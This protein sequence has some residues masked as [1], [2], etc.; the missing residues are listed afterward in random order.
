MSSS[1]NSQPPP[2]SPFQGVDDMPSGRSHTSGT[3]YSNKNEYLNNMSGGVAP[4][5]TA[6][7][8]AMMGMP[9]HVAG[10]VSHLTNSNVMSSPQI[11]NSMFHTNDAL[12]ME[13]RVGAGVAGFGVSNL[14]EQPFGL[15]GY[16][17]VSTQELFGRQPVAGTASARG[18]IHSVGQ[19]VQQAALY[20]NP[21]FVGGLR[22]DIVEGFNYDLLTQRG[23]SPNNPAAVASSYNNTITQGQQYQQ[24]GMRNM[25]AAKLTDARQGSE[26]YLQTAVRM[27]SGDVYTGVGNLANSIANQYGSLDEAVQTEGARGIGRVHQAEI[28][29]GVLQQAAVRELEFEG[30]SAAAAQVGYNAGVDNIL[31]DG[32]FTG[33][34]PSGRETFVT[35]AGLRDQPIPLTSSE[36]ENI[37]DVAGSYKARSKADAEDRAVNSFLNPDG[38]ASPF[39]I[40]GDGFDSDM[41]PQ[42]GGD[43]KAFTQAVRE[44]TQALKGLS[45]GGGGMGMG[46][47]GGGGGAGGGGGRIT[48]EDAL[49][50]LEGAGST[51]IGSRQGRLYQGA[52]LGSATGFVSGLLGGQGT[53]DDSNRRRAMKGMGRAAASVV[54][55]AAGS[56]GGKIGAS[57]EAQLASQPGFDR[58]F[59]GLGAFR[60]M[61]NM[62][63][64]GELPAL[65]ASMLMGGSGTYA[66]MRSAFGGMG[67]GEG[68]GISKEQM[69]GLIMPLA[70]SAGGGTLDVTKTVGAFAAGEDV[71]GY[72]GLMGQQRQAGITSGHAMEFNAAKARGLK[73]SAATGFASS[74]Y[75]A[76][77]GM[78]A[79][80]NM[81]QDRARTEGRILS[82]GQGNIQRGAGVFGRGAGV[83][84]GAKDLLLSPFQ[85]VSDIILANEALSSTGSYTGAVDRLEQG[86]A[87]GGVGA[88][89]R[90]NAVLG[91]EMG[92]LAMRQKG[93]SGRD[94]RD[95]ARG[96]AS[97]GDGATPNFDI[98]TSGKATQ[99]SGALAGR[100]N[101]QLDSLY[102]RMDTFT[103]MLEADK[104]VETFLLKRLDANI[105]KM[106]T[107]LT[108]VEKLTNTIDTLVISSR[109]AAVA[110][111]NDTSAWQTTRLLAMGAYITILNQ[112]GLK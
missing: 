44:A 51:R 70:S 23:V 1:N 87:G 61:G 33:S 85:G 107:L 28:A 108:S 9:A 2:S 75:G 45:G 91:E 52:F 84:R 95:V 101:E 34:I 17:P 35:H 55:G 93:L 48:T 25:T 90:L 38:G 58:G 46:G 12:S 99:V 98:A 4:H 103:K 31:A 89:G 7:P 60:S 63:A 50:S 13:R 29:G 39:G 80:M 66:D 21:E 67:A 30:K 110:K 73:G 82:M 104:K 97:L 10:A 57:V 71:S 8:Q 15:D 81:G 41:K 105:D 69:G 43:L 36:M 11:V 20:S 96:G 47:G 42:K 68:F 18:N 3:D 112:L 40:G 59:E 54:R 32:T 62:A 74:L 24:L 83:F 77:A 19:M 88:R 111:F 65:Q 53:E 106:S 37:F 27:A 6:F 79:S 100:R 102:T 49:Q 109:D 56:F 72:Y 5:P 78:D 22:Q 76:F 94:V 26:N 64:G 14:S 92:G 16:D 86:E